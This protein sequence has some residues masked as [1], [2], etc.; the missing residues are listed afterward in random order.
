MSCG[1]IEELQVHRSRVSQPL[2]VRRPSWVGFL[3]GKIADLREMRA[4]VRAVGGN[5][6][7]V[8]VVSGIWVRLGAI[9]VKREKLAVRG[10]RRVRIVKVARGNLALGLRRQCEGIKVR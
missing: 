5:H 9:A 3:P 2:A 8:R 1:V 6:P 4:F 7:N 10:P